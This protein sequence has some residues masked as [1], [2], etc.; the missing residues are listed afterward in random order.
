VAARLGAHVLLTDQSKLLATLRANA[1]GNAPELERQPPPDGSDDNSPPS[2]AGV[3]TVTVSVETRTR[4]RTGTRTRTRTRTRTKTKTKTR[5]STR[6]RTRTRKRRQQCGIDTGNVSCSGTGS[7]SARDSGN[8]GSSGGGGGGMQGSWRA[9]EL[10]FFND[11]KDAV[12]WRRQARRG[13]G[14]GGQEGA[15][16]G[17]NDDDDDLFDLVVAA[18]VVYLK[19][20]WDAMAFTIKAL[21]KPDGEALM[22][23]EQRR[24]NVDGFFGPPRFGAHGDCWEEGKELDFRRDVAEEG[25]G[26]GGA[27]EAA[28]VRIYR[29]RR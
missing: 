27:A 11:E 23:F 18:D 9:E 25:L 4:T 13:G 7:V 29:M 19:D 1:R 3:E 24:S 15:F 12:R 22:A 17:D 8:S 14:G 20:L 28:K 5:T 26:L 16:D 21:L 2:L 6:T 10:L